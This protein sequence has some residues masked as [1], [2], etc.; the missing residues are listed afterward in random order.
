MRDYSKY[1]KNPESFITNINTTKDKIIVT[2]SSGTEWTYDLTKE[3][4]TWLYQILSTQYQEV[5]ANSN[6]VTSNNLT[7]IFG[8][9]LVLCGI[10]LFG[11]FDTHIYEAIMPLSCLSLVGVVGSITNEGIKNY[12]RRTIAKYKNIISSLS[13][14]KEAVPVEENILKPL[15][16]SAHSALNTEQ[17]LESSNLVDNMFN[18]NWIDHMSKSDLIKLQEQ[19][20]I[21]QG[22][23][24][25]VEI[26]ST[27]TK[28]RV[29]NSEK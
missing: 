18:I 5:I 9:L 16:N 11:S 19:I 1:F 23:N 20:K 15:S 21:Y 8:C 10:L 26:I 29:P 2:F 4:I 3:N 22:L 25:T 28:K 7:Q 6:K 13:I 14:L 27:K 17:E 24:D 12:H